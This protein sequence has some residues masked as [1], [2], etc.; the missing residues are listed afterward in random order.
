[1]A[2][3]FRADEPV[4]EAILRCSREQLDR[5]VS[6][7][8]EE[9]NEDPTKAIHQARKAIKKQR[10]LLR[11]ARG[12][13]KGSQ[14]RRENDALRDAARALSAT[15]DADVMIASVDDLAERFAGQLPAKTFKSIRTRLE[16]RRRAAQTASPDGQ[17]IPELGAVRLRVDEWQLRRGGWKAIDSGLDRTYRRGRRALRRARK[18]G[19]MEELHDWRKRVKDLWYHERLLAPTGGPAIRGHAKDLD[20]LSDLLGDDHDLAV[21]R[22]ELTGEVRAVPVDLD[23]VLKL[24][25]H[26]RDELQTEAF[27]IGERVYAESPKAFRRRLQRSWKAG[28][29]L[30]RVPEEQHPAELAAATRKPRSD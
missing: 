14:R 29:K 6:A 25:D 17:A 2:Y 15:R 28:R 23:A 30:A 11:L 9:I 13:M 4:R 12:T 7:L 24:I 19:R 16:K 8:S 22:E 18:S 20:H 26:R 21:L 5:A 10:S 1:M 27:R 3:K